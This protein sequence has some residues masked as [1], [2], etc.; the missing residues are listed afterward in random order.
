[1]LI[2]MIIYRVEVEGRAHLIHDTMNPMIFKDVT[3]GFP[4]PGY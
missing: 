2:F 1:M 4:L 3:K